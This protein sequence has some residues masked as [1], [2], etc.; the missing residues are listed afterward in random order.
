[1]INNTPSPVRRCLIASRCRSTLAAASFALGALLASAPAFSESIMGVTGQ[2]ISVQ[3]Q[4]S[5]LLIVLG[6]LLGGMIFR[7]VFRPLPADLPKLIFKRYFSSHPLPIILFDVDTAG[8]IAANK[9]ACTLY[10]YTRAEFKRLSMDQLRPA[11]DVPA[12]RRKLREIAAATHTAGSAGEWTHLRNGGA[13][14][15][16]NVSYQISDFGNKKSCYVICLDVSKRRQAELEV[17][18]AKSMLETVLNSVPQRIYWKNKH[19]EYIGCNASFAKEIGLAR[20]EDVYGLTDAEL[21]WR[22]DAADARSR[23]AQAMSANGGHIAY[24]HPAYFEPARE[25]RW[26]AKTKVPLLDPDGEVMGVLTLHDDITTR[27]AAELALRLRSRA[28]DACVNAVVMTRAYGKQHLIDYVN[29]AFERITGYTAAQVMGRDCRFLQGDERQQEGLRE[30][31]AALKTDAEVSTIL[32][33]YRADGRMFWNQLLIAPVLDD[34]GIATHHIAIVNDV[35]ELVESRNRLARQ[36]SYD[37][38]TQ[39]P[40]RVLLSERLRQAISASILAGT[41]L[42]VVFLDMDHFKDVNDSLGHSVGD[43]LLQQVAERLLSAS[44]PTMTVARYGGDEFVILIPNI[45]GYGHV[46]VILRRLQGALAP[47]M[48]IDEHEFYIDCSMGVSLFPDDGSDAET[49]IKRADAAMYEAKSMGRNTVRRYD[50]STGTR[51]QVRLSAAQNLRRAIRDTEFCLYYQPQINVATGRVVAVEALI[52]WFDPALG[53]I[54]PGEFIPLAEESGLIVPIGEWVIGEV[55]STVVELSARYDGLR[56][57]VNLSP[58][59]FTQGNVVEFLSRSMAATGVNP[60][61]LELEITESTLASPCTG[62]ALKTLAARGAIIAIDD[63]GTGYSNLSSL[64]ALGPD[65]LKIDKS[66]V[67][68]IGVSVQDEALV[69][70]VLALGIAFGAQVIAE[71]V[72]TIQQRDFL[73]E[74]GCNEMQ[75]Y[76]FARPMPLEELHGFLR[77]SEYHANANRKP[78]SIGNR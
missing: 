63:F 72:E 30:I 13:E 33:N 34:T 35:T 58:R 68:G 10:G 17:A 61:Q 8:I 42:A 57:A 39:L 23:D 40:N 20:A 73:M 15:T 41:Q 27:K 66:L 56:V 51:A 46:D 43:R 76:L 16:V 37:A 59:Q 2:T 74:H 32:R 26:Y 48:K 31:R 78:Q 21:P 29:P 22:S 5:L 1:M 64:K 50:F 60:E 55:C 11:R 45:A 6:V 14:L 12:F 24:E 69:L 54:S 49:L 67:N 38:L 53:P 65:R 77:R 9:H 4:E 62:T 75:G 28:L 70:A 52:R 71:G 3:V 36:A 47:S 44:S 18:S 19:S 7:S 25:L